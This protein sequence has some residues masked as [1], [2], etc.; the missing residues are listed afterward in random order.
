MLEVGGKTILPVR[1]NKALLE[2]PGAVERLLRLEQELS[3]DPTTAARAGHLQ[4]VAR[5]V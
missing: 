1:Q 5:R 4:I 2:Q 3:K